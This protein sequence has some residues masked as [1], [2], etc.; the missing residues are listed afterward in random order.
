[1]P[2][3]E[4]IYLGMP[5]HQAA[6]AGAYRGLY[7]HASHPRTQ[8]RLC[9][10]ECQGSLLAYSF[11]HLWCE[12]A[13]YYQ[14]RGFTHFA[15]LHSDV[16]PEEWWLD[17]LLDEMRA[18][19][20]DVLSAVVP[21]KCGE[22]LTSTALGDLHDP[23]AHPRRLTIHEVANLPET[24]D[25]A[26]AGFPDKILLVNTGC[27][28]AKLGS[29]VGDFPGFTVQDRLIRHEGRLVPQVIPEDWNASRWWH[30]RGLRVLATSKVRLH[31]EGP[32]GWSAG[33]WRQGAEPWGLWD[34]DRE[35]LP[36]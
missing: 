9:V 18:T 3:T 34:Y 1:M 35:T 29:W 17:I 4:V 16:A 5:R 25:A 12:C 27:W 31:H 11:N 24:F 7:W 6:T 14:E 32:W 2:S 21:L 26:Q 13:N 33:G 15:M 36:A 28:L 30:T 19:N 22:G 20:A 23:W 8:R 10:S